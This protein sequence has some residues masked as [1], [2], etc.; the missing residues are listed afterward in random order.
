MAKYKQLAEKFIADIQTGKLSYGD[1]MLSLRQLSRQHNISLST[2]VNCYEELESLGWLIS[3]PQAGFYVSSQQSEIQSPEWHPFTSSVST[4]EPQRFSSPKLSGAKLSGPLGRSRSSLDQDS[5]AALDNCFR[6]AM[7]RSA[8]KVE[9]YPELQGEKV[10]RE[11]LANHFSHNGFGLNSDELVVTHGC[12]DAVKIALEA[13]TKAGDTVAVS[14]PCYDGLLDLLAQLSL[15]IL[16]IPSL[17]DGIDLVQLEEHLR[18][19]TIQAGLF[20]TTHMNPQGITMSMQQKQQLADFANQYQIPMIEDDVY[21]ELSHHNQ[22]PLPASYYDMHG[23]MIWCGSVSKTL[24]PS[25]RVG[26]CRPGRYLDVILKRSF[27]VPTLIQFAIADFIDS[28]AYAKRLKHL[29]YRLASQYQVYLNY[30]IEH[31]PEGSRVT[32]P[33]GGLVLWIQVPNLN[34]A[35]FQ[36]AVQADILDIRVGP[37]FTSSNRYQDCIR[38]NMGFA[39]D[40]SV[41][42]EL[43]K[44]IRL[45]NRNIA[46]C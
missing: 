10:L 25:Y 28:G 40:E 37:L 12:I 46:E 34:I 38:I 13:C 36:E 35:Q 24:S 6:R 1:R 15:N 21:L 17:N 43:D 4:L 41:K 32:Q 2:A 7:K 22:M 30:L 44:M 9:D 33:D 42:K 8:Q 39:L 23:Y 20:C 27:G 16:E 18:L 19:G 26:W 29:R 5:R 3:K 45:I 14:S 31:L 11:A